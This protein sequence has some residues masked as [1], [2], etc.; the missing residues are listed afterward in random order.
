MNVLCLL[1]MRDVEIYF[2]KMCGFGLIGNNES[3]TLRKGD[4]LDVIEKYGQ[5]EALK[6]K[7]EA[8]TRIDELERENKE[9]KHTVK[10]QL[11]FLRSYEQS[12]L[13]EGNAVE[14][15][16]FFTRKDMID[17]ATSVYND[18]AD[19]PGHEPTEADLLDWLSK[20]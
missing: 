18:V 16:K 10:M 19:L 12:K 15:A 13:S 4:I 3:I 2:Q 11:D 8:K 20:K 6:A 9:L 14:F 17:F 7:D 1:E 5:M